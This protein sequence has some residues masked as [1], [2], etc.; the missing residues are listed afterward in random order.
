MLDSLFILFIFFRSDFIVFVCVQIFFLEQGVFAKMFLSVHQTKA[1]HICT[2]DRRRFHNNQI[3]PLSLTGHKQYL[4]ITS[5]PFNTF[6]IICSFSTSYQRTIWI[7]ICLILEN[8]AILINQSHLV[9]VNLKGTIYISW[10]FA[11]SCLPVKNIVV[12][13][14]PLSTFY[15]AKAARKRA[16]SLSVGIFPLLL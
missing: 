5:A 11:T 1:F 4:S 8:K 15:M 6:S 16:L 13:K 10:G 3:C 9:T 2:Y 14:L 12:I 7:M